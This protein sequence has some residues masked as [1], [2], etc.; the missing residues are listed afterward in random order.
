MRF[1]SLLFVASVLVATSA[2]STGAPKRGD[3][4]CV[5]DF[6]SLSTIVSRDYAGYRDKASAQRFALAALTDSTRRTA[7]AATDGAT[8][9]AAL[10]RWVR[11]FQDP[12][13]Q[14]FQIRTA[15]AAPEATAA[16]A[17]P[18]SRPTAPQP[19]AVDRRR[20]SITFRG[21][22]T[23]VLVLAD[24][25]DRYK[26]VIDSLVAANREQLLRTP[27]LII[28]VRR[29]GG[30]W[31]GSYESVIPLLYTNP[32]HVHGMDAWASEGNIEYLR[33]M[34]RSS[35]AEEIRRV[36]GE[37]L[38]KMEAN[39]GSFVTINDDRTIAL[40]TVFPMPRMV[41]VL[42]GRG[43]VSACEQFVLDARQSRKVTVVGTGNTGGFTDYG[44]ARRVS[45]PSGERA[46][47]VPSARSKRL[48]DIR[49]DVVGIEPE[50]MVSADGVDPVAFA[51][52][53]LQRRARR[54]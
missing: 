54:K 31:T 24:F 42:I 19:P 52:Q 32:I 48:P 40:D 50:I 14:V 22:S 18:P 13:L 43:C 36:V 23:A 12:H 1:R 47:Q 7:T 5:G 28:D 10:D 6:D 33:S 29:N 37:L 49:F 26:R 53:L 9:T 17:Q 30:G 16:A 25:G 4:G 41:G 21:D 38:P 35:R 46:A 11:F 45:L 44:N 20:P 51:E 39:R 15:T 2:S 27:V 3:G 34:L 8:C